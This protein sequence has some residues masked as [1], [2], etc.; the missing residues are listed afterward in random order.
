MAD[1]DKIMERKE[2]LGNFLKVKLGFD[3]KYGAVYIGVYILVMAVLFMYFGKMF[4]SGKL[5]L[6]VIIPF[7]TLI[8][9]LLGKIN[10]GVLINLVGWGFIIRIQNLPILKDVTTGGY[11]PSD[12]DAFAF[13]RYAQYILEH[14]KLMAVDTMRYYPLGF[15]GLDEFSFLSRFIVYLYKFL[16]F[17]SSSITLE[18]ADV[19]Y[20]AVA[21]AIGIVFFYLFVKKLFN[22]RAALIASAFLVVVPAFLYRSMGG[23]SDKEALGIMFMFAFFYSYVCSLKS[24]SLKWALVHAFL[25]GFATALT[26]L[27]WGG[28]TTI[29]LVVGL[30]IIVELFLGKL[31]R[32]DIY[33]YLIYVFVTVL[34][35][36]YFSDTRYTVLG[37]VTSITSGVMIVAL[38]IALIHLILFDY[39][40]FGIKEMIQKRYPLGIVSSVLA[41]V[42]GSIG[43][44]IIYGPRYFF[45]KGKD[46]YIYLTQPFGTNRWEL[47]VAENQQPYITDWAGQFGGWAYIWIFIIGSVFLFYLLIKNLERKNIWKLAGVYII[48]IIGFIFSRYN[49]SSVFDGASTIAKVVYIG[50]LVVFMVF[51][52]WF[53]INSFYNNKT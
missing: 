17:F 42:L 4:N 18:F 41:A 1:P 48:F 24:E 29:F 8:L 38:V 45:E 3:R 39:N 40:V 47:T 49:P 51:C 10:L 9:F 12:L 33:A 53:Y 43:I 19:L 22:A 36:V 16:H 50:S 2:K 15:T 44:I 7:V 5:W 34:L 35:L 30:T 21:T 23:V 27:A 25:A 14:G 11:I 31:K 6:F 32:V 37:F 28:V 46:V 13:L 26:G 20:P 52:L